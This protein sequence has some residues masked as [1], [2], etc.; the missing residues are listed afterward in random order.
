[1]F[2][3]PFS[4]RS[5]CILKVRPEFGSTI[6][7]TFMTFILFLPP[8]ATIC[9][10]LSAYMPVVSRPVIMQSARFAYWTIHHSNSAKV[11]FLW[12][13]ETAYITWRTHVFFRFKTTAQI[14]QDCISRYVSSVHFVFSFSLPTSPQSALSPST[15]S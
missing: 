14:F 5:V 6:Y 13:I 8:N 2:K 15:N 12:M 3:S 4:N 10:A 11:V 1:M 9:C 7:S